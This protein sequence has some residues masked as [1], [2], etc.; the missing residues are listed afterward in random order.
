MGVQMSSSE[1]LHFSIDEIAK[2]MRVLTKHSFE[3]PCLHCFEEIMR[4]AFEIW[5]VGI[6]KGPRSPH[7]WKEKKGI[8]SL[9]W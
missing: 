9:V 6:I 7:W 8:D 4:E 5:K 3:D 1:Q 2:I